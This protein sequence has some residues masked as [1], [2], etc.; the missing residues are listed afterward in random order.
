MAD[1]MRVTLYL[2]D[3]LGRRA[4]DAGLNLSGLLRGAVDRELRGEETEGARRVTGAI[5]SARAVPGGT[6][7]VVFI[8][9]GAELPSSG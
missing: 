7:L 8:P 5:V 1:P 6:E 9:E 2:P 4:K 3:A